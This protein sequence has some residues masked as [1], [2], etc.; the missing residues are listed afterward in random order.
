[1]EVKAFSPCHITGFF[2]ICD[3]STNPLEVGSRGAG[4]CI[5]RGLLTTVHLE[6]SSKPKLGITINGKVTKA[7]TSAYVI[8]HFFS[9]LVED[10]Y[11]V[12]VR[13]ECLVPVG[14]GF[15]SSGA[16]ALSLS[17]ALNEGLGAGLSFEEVAQIAHIAEIKCRTGLGAVSALVQGGFEVRVKAGAPGVADIKNLPIS[18]D[19]QVICLCFGPL[20]TEK[21]LA[22]RNFRARVNSASQGLV[23]GLLKDPL[24][25]NFSSLSRKFST[26]LGILTRRLRRLMDEAL[27]HGFCS[28]MAMLGDCAFSLVKESELPTLLKVFEKHRSP[29]SSLIISKVDVKGAR[30]L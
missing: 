27:D 24:P 19:Y 4:I 2:E 26:S 30:L 15:S 16:G 5:E 17:L 18:D 13:H 11:R 12:D 25:S 7:R 20:P 10:S 6:R 21:L 29:T 23:E 9:K 8:R 14:A 22:D 1:V 28:S 3:S